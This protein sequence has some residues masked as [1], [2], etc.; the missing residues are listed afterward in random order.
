MPRITPF[1]FEE[2]PVEE[3]GYVVVQCSV[4][5]GDLP[6]KIF[7]KFN[8]T[9]IIDSDGVSV[10]SVGKRSSS[11]TIESVTHHHAG[12]YTC[13]G[14]NKVGQAEYSTLLQVNGTI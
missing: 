11:L 6:L 5:T 3:G 13:I 8:G 9:L 2:N 12:Y 1:T 7:W 14:Q 10:T 4:A